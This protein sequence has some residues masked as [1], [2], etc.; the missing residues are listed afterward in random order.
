MAALM[1]AG[2]LAMYET[3]CS[4]R[5][6]WLGTGHDACGSASMRAHLCVKLIHSS[7]KRLRSGQAENLVISLEN[8][9]YCR[10][11]VLRD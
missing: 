1:H 7:R 10:T 8:K 5:S 2:V 3:K 6:G 4:W 11:K 9:L